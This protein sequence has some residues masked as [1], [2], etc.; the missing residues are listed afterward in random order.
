MPRLKKKAYIGRDCV[1]CGNC[2]KHCPVGAISI[3]EGVYAT[4]EREKCVGCGKCAK[5]CPAGVINILEEG[6]KY[7]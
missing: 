6:E 7:I 4:V 5:A 1:A 3:L 2:I